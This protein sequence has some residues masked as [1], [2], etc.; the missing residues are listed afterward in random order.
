[1]MPVSDAARTSSG[2][3]AEA[4]A[5]LDSGVREESN[6]C[7]SCVDLY[8]RAAL[9]AWQ[10]LECEPAALTSDPDCPT[11]WQVYQESLGRLLAT[12]AQYSRLDPRNHLIIVEGGRRRAVPIEYYGFA[13][14]SYEFCQVLPASDAGW[15]GLQNYYRTCGLGVSLVAVRH[16]GCEEL[17]YRRNQPFAVTAVLRPRPNVGVPPDGDLPA[18]NS[19]SCNTVLAF[20]N[21]CLLD[22]LPVGPT[23]VAMERDISAPFVYLQR[24]VAP[25]LH[26]RLPRPGR[27]QGPTE[28]VDDGTLSAGQSPRRLD[29]WSVVGSHDLDRYRQRAARPKRHL[30]P[31]PVLVLPIPDGRRIAR[32][33]RG[34]PREAAPST[35]TLRSTT[36]GRRDGTNGAGGPQHGRI[37]SATPGHLLL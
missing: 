23:V 28:A 31:I 18:C 6:G 7:E 14:K 36:P 1:M 13:W 2:Y 24:E 15:R 22:S 3:L 21:P 30:S 11:A 12:A 4:R 29:P 33:G 37:G 19:A 26:R 20:Y 32:I 34:T 8:Y 17:F 35:G 27:C 9:S 25:K 10:Q 5:C 16:G